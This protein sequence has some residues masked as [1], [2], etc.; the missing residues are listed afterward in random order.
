MPTRMS[1]AAAGVMRTPVDDQEEVGRAALGNVAVVCEQDGFVE[2]GGL[3]VGD[4]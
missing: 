4:S 2:A 1:S 3:R